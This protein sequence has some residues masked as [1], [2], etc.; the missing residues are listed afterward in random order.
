MIGHLF[1]EHTYIDLKAPVNIM[2]RLYYNWIMGDRL[3]PRQDPYNPNR[4]CNFVGRARGLH[5]FVGNFSYQCD[6]MILEDVRGIIDP[7]LGEIVLGKPFIEVSNMTYEQDEGI[8][9]FSHEDRYVKYMMPYKSE[10]FKDVE[11]LDVDNIPTFEVS[12]V[13]QSD[14]R[15]KYSGC[16]ALGPE[17]KWDKEVI[18]R[19]RTA[20]RLRF[21]KT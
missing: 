10:K 7:H 5:V 3:E 14:N 1:R 4:T 19:F 2:S 20:F 15:I 16:M 18:R 17:Y 21:G 6:F 12:N 11:N 13:N 9:T 8:A